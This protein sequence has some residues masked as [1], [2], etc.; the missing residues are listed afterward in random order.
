[1]WSI[2]ARE[3]CKYKAWKTCTHSVEILDHEEQRWSEYFHN[4]ST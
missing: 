1:M 4:F 3:F 2:R